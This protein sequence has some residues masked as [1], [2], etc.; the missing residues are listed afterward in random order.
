MKTW[1]QFLETLNDDGMPSQRVPVSAR[2]RRKIEVPAQVT[3]DHYKDLATKH[4]H[5]DTLGFTAEFEPTHRNK[6]IP[7]LTAMVLSNQGGVVKMLF[8]YGGQ[9]SEPI[10]LFKQHWEPLGAAGLN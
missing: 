3:P 6:K 1:Q 9:G 8:S 7:E 4:G 2:I 5:K 10:A